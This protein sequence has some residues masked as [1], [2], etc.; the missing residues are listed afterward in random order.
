LNPRIAF[1]STNLG[2]PWGGSEELWSRTA[3]DLLGQGFRVS[4]SVD[5]W[6]PPHPRIRNL[7]ERGVEVSF[8]PVPYPLW[9]RARRALIARRKTPITLEVQRLFATRRPGFVVISEA[10]AFPPI[11][12]L[13]LC[14]TL[15]LP[16]VTVQQAN[17]EWFWVLDDLAERYRIALGAAQRC[18]FVS[19]A[20]QRLTEKQIGCELLNAEVVWN[21]VNLDFNASPPWPQLGPRGEFR[22]A[23]V[24]RLDPRAKGQD[25]LFEALAGSSWAARPWRLHLYGDGPMRGGLER[26]A[27]HLGLSHRVAF[28]GHLAVE[29]IWPLN[30]VLIMPS[31]FEGMPLAI[32]EA[33][34]CGRPVIATD[35][36]GHAEVIED[37]VTGFLADAPT[38]RSVATALERFWARRDEAEE[39]GAAA[40]KRIRQ[41][42]PPDPVRIFSDKIKEIL[43]TGQGSLTFD[44]TASS[45]RES[46]APLSGQ[47]GRG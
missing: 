18:F 3:L 45:L 44:R 41:L 14:I 21:P 16:F 13:E 20:N 17:T 27:H 38:A 10:G 46:R 7:I 6:S 25:V 8:R 22:L 2:D 42:V 23:C 29:E 37:G 32:I 9:R 15:R 36:A 11:D 26:L 47:P 31:R 1:I 12:L 19:K 30:H 28:E 34:L 4:A 24:A 40:A 35:V 5:K 39:M 33:M 43:S